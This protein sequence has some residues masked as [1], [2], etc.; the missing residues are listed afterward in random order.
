MNLSN[1]EETLVKLIE[2]LKKRFGDKILE[3]NIEPKRIVKVL[4]S[5]ECIKDVA[6]YLK[7]EWRMDYIK[8]VTGVDLSRLSDK[9][10]DMLEIIYHVSSLSLEV[11]KGVTLSLSTKVAIS[12]PVIPSLTSV[13]KGAEMHEREVY[14]MLGVNFEGH[15]DLRRLLLPEFWSD[16]PPLRKDYVVPGREG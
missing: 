13:W 3:V 16:K 14:E 4:V 5:S 8:G 11:L 7:S 2:D 6:N 9:A 15:P 12:N 10:Q 1:V